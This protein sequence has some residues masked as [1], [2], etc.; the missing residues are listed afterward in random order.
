LGPLRPLLIRFRCSPHYVIFRHSDPATSLYLILR[1]EAVIHFKPYDGPRMLLT[2]LR[3]GGVLGWSSVMG[4]PSYSSDA[5]SE[6]EIEAVRVE[7]SVL[8][9]FCLRHPETGR[10]LLGRLQSSRRAGKTPARKFRQSWDK[11]S[12][13]KSNCRDV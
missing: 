7:G 13:K 6:T 1:G 5:S 2:R 8:R 11:A 10:I 4:S 12:S 9:R 3:A